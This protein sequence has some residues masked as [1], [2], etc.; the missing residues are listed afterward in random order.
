MIEQHSLPCSLARNQS[1]CPVYWAAT[2]VGQQNDLSL[3]TDHVFN[4]KSFHSLVGSNQN[5]ARCRRDLDHAGIRNFLVSW[6]QRL[7]E[8]SGQP[9]LTKKRD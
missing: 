6:K 9:R 4:P 2:F 8:V 7:K 1:G 5:I 3:M